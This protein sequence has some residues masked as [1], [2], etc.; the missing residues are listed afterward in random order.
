[1][2]ANPRNFPREY[3]ALFMDG[4]ENPVSPNNDNAI[5]FADQLSAGDLD[6]INVCRTL[7][8]AAGGAPSA[9]LALIAI[10]VSRFSRGAVTSST[11]KAWAKNLLG[12][13]NKN[14]DEPFNGKV[15]AIGKLSCET[16]SSAGQ[17]DAVEDLLAK[18]LVDQTPLQL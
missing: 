8:E 15:A 10:G 18:F 2:L 7:Q 6:E 5:L 14:E 3:I 12:K 13:F 9:G 16:L 17:L 11:I 4:Q 1:M